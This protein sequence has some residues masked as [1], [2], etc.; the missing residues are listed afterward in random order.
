M[1]RRRPKRNVLREEAVEL[2]ASLRR[3]SGKRRSSTSNQDGQE[4]HLALETAQKAEEERLNALPF[5]ARTSHFIR[6][7]AALATVSTTEA[8]REEAFAWVERDDG[9][10]SAVEAAAS[11][12]APMGSLVQQM[13]ETAVTDEQSSPTS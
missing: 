13:V 1:R 4:Q 8:A 9:A 11:E 6:E 10:P 12:T 2:A 3:A 5:P 7:A